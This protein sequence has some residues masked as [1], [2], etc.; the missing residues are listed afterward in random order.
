[1]KKRKLWFYLLVTAAVVLIV[2]GIL[3]G[4]FNTVWEK[5]RTVCLECVGIG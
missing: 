3:N 5:A 2:F 4:E 1:M